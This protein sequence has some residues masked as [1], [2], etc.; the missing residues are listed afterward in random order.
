MREVLNNRSE[1][2]A[3]A[4]GGPMGFF[5]KMKL[6]VGIGGAKVEVKLE[7]GAVPLG[8]FVKGQVIIRAGKSEQKCNGVPTL[9]KRSSVVMVRNEDGSKRKETRWDTLAE[10]N[11]AAYEVTLHPGS[12]YTYDFTF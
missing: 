9:L 1:V 7:P 5:D 2:D 3:S 10:E 11:L 12:E 4:S 6:A 8:G